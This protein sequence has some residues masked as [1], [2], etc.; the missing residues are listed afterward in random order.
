MRFALKSMMTLPARL[1]AAMVAAIA[2]PGLAH[3]HHP[4]GGMMPTTF[5]DGFLSGIGHPVLGSDHLAF[6]VGIGLIVAMSRRWTWLP[7]AFVVTLLPGVLTHVQGIGLGPVEVLV[8]LSVVLIGAA[9]LFEDR[10]PAVVLAGAAMLAG[11]FH[12][13][14]FGETIV[15]AESA[16]LGAYLLGLSVMILGMTTAIALIGRRL[17]VAGPAPVLIQRVAAGLLIVGGGLLT[18]QSLVG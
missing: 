11:F 6:I 1:A 8:A 5:A 4:S 17:L 15:G 2:L 10:I 12:G 16:P 7:L 13:Y 3:A 14:A 9:L 18:L